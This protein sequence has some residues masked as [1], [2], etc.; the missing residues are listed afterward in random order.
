[1]TGALDGIRVLDLTEYVAGPF[2]G[3]LLADM[4]ADVLKLEPPSGD[5]WRL[6][7]MVAADESRNFLSVNRGKRSLVVD[8]KTPEGKEIAYRAVARSDVVLSSYRPGVAERLGMDYAALSAIKPDLIYAKNTA[9]GSVGPY[10]GKPG[11]DLVAQAMTG[12]ISFESFGRAE[13]PQGITSAAITD[14]CAG[15]NLAYAVVCAIVQRNA[16]GEGQEVE[17]SLFA[18]GI[19][20]QYRPLMSIDMFD[21]EGRQAL[22]E[23]LD[24]ASAQGSRRDEAINDPDAPGYQRTGAPAL[25]TNPYY[26]VYKTRDSHM[27]IACLNNR[28]RRASARLLGVDD[29]R[30]EIEEWD[31][32]T[33]DPDDAAKLNAQIDAIFETKT[34]EE[35]CAAFEAQG[36]PCG[37]VRITEELYEDPHVRAQDLIP[38]LDHPLVGPIRVAGSPIHMSAAETG[39]KVAS[40]TLGQHTREVL[41]ELGYGEDEIAALIRDKVVRAP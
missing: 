11:F 8:L 39:A 37:P 35:W 4:G 18:S 31:S 9:F 21:L 15:M 6:T 33:L 41:V 19:A 29:P 26:N 23:R 25:A 34:T 17:T 16:T 22:I 7:N 13:R 3:Q 38:E 10:A 12:I 5:Q 28:L 27:V 32:T 2:A 30:V 20:L 24:E 1:M 14:Y 36:V 40:P